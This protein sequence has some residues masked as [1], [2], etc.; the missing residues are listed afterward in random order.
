VSHSPIYAIC[1]K[2]KILNCHRR[3][4]TNSI[5]RWHYRWHSFDGSFLSLCYGRPMWFKKLSSLLPIVCLFAMIVYLI[6]DRFGFH[7]YFNR[8]MFLFVI[9]FICIFK[10][11]FTRFKIY[12]FIYISTCCFFC[13]D[14]LFNFCSFWVSFII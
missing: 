7:L 12:L 14:C 1:T 9:S 11:S 13:H 5:H 3:R 10:L 4:L 2:S 8:K 6:C